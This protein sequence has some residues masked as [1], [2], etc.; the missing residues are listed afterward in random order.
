MDVLLRKVLIMEYGI[1]GRRGRVNVWNVGE[2][3]R[4]KEA[5]PSS[6]MACIIVYNNMTW[7]CY[8]VKY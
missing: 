5:P 1:G 7:M 8:S 6:G 4:R 3:E 2:E